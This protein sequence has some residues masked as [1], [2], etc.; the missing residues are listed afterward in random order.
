MI[1][2][3][4]ARCLHSRAYAHQRRQE[5][6]TGHHHVTGTAKRLERRIEVVA[7]ADVFAEARE[8]LA[9]LHRTRAHSPSGSVTPA[10]GA[11]K[12]AGRASAVRDIL[13]RCGGQHTSP[14]GPSRK[15][16]S[17]FITPPSSFSA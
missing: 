10:P 11:K 2:A 15:S 1:G 3:N 12:Q 14:V 5:R 7:F 4:G 8:I 16:S 13:Q 17:G 6:A 9:G